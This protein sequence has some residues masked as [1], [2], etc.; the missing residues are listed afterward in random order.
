MQ[1]SSLN[2]QKDSFIS[3]TQPLWKAFW[4]LYFIGGLS[5]TVVFISI[6]KILSKSYF[7]L[8]ISQAFNLKA[9]QA[10]V[11]FVAV[12]VMMYLGY[13]LFCFLSVW[14]CSINSVSKYWALLAKSLILMHLVW[15]SWKCYVAFGG[16]VAYFSH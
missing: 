11:V 8:E 14:R 10:L 5:F 4:L 3:G 12:F 2:L 9:E 13:F 16:L 15:V 1:D 7:L 6:I